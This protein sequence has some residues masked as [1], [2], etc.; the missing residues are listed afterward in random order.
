LTCAFAT[1]LQLWRVSHPDEHYIPPRIGA[2]VHALF[3]AFL[4]TPITAD[5]ATVAN[6]WVAASFVLNQRH[7]DWLEAVIQRR[8]RDTDF[9][10]WKFCYHGLLH[11]WAALD[12]KQEGKFK[13]IPQGSQELVPGVSENLWNAD[14]VMMNADLSVEDDIHSPEPVYRFRGDTALNGREF[15]DSDDELAD[16]MT[17]EPEPETP[18]VSKRIPLY[19]FTD[20]Y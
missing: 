6:V 14:G 16:D 10:A 4:A 19:S 1:N 15:D 11:Q 17:T 20:D 3:R 5:A 8:I 18:D 9:F 2:L 12:G 13:S 7:R